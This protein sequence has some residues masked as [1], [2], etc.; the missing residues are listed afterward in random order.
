MPSEAKRIKKLR[1]DIPRLKAVKANPEQNPY[2]FH[3][4]IIKPNMIYLVLGEVADIRHYVLL[5][6]R[7][8]RIIPGMFHIES[9]VEADED[10]F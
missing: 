4:D 9:F 6:L 3:N 7:T 1:Q 2:I 10:D 8:G 5:E